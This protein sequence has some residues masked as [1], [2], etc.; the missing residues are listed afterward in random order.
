MRYRYCRMLEEDCFRGR[1][2]DFVFMF[3]FGGIVITVSFNVK[4]S[5][6]TDLNKLETRGLL[7]YQTISDITPANHRQE[8]GLCS[9]IW[10]EGGA[11]GEFLII[12]V[13]TGMFSST[14]CPDRQQ[15]V[16]TLQKQLLLS[17]IRHK[18]LN[19][20]VLSNR[21]KNKFS[22]GH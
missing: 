20:S 6:Y 21:Q 13:F 18:V 19:D 1:T 8:K 4:K 9:W 17:L 7:A 12:R 3:L 14:L 2:A 16:G 22:T 10:R 5:S 15:E 11:L